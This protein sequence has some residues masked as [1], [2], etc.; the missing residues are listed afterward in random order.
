VISLFSADPQD[1]SAGDRG[2]VD[3]EAHGGAVMGAADAIE[4]ATAASANEDIGAAGGQR[5]AGA[6]EASSGGH[7][8]AGE[9]QGMAVEAK[10]HREEGPREEEGQS[11]QEEEEEEEEEKEEEKEEEEE[12]KRLRLEEE[13]NQLREKD[14]ARFTDMAKSI[15]L[16]GAVG[17]V[18]CAPPARIASLKHYCNERSGEI[19]IAIPLV[20]LHDISYYDKFQDGSKVDLLYDPREDDD[21]EDADADPVFALRRA[22]FKPPEQRSEEMKS[23]LLSY[24]SA[25]RRCFN[26]LT[27]VDVDSLCLGLQHKLCPARCEIFQQ[28]SIHDACYIVGSGK[29]ELIST[30]RTGE[31]V[32]ELCRSLGPGAYFGEL[33]VVRDDGVRT[34]SAV[35]GEAE[36]ELL[37]VTRRHFQMM[38]Q[39]RHLREIMALARKDPGQ[40]SPDDLS[41]LLTFLGQKF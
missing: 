12:E 15:M 40:R 29:V 31:P 25:F 21:E 39:E 33:G 37:V 8:T 16:R 14:G 13:A 9:E 36:V 6:T 2:E 41:E 38:A 22:V 24:L 5:F 32:A 19:F 35:S 26:D 10:G 20:L 23:C 7:D 11:R 30:D 4:R 27:I 34:C 28:G 18:V 17:L 3:G 1:L